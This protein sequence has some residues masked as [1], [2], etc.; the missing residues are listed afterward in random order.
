MFIEPFQQ[1]VRS[2]GADPRS[3]Q[4]V[5]TSETVKLVRNVGVTSLNL[6]QASLSDHPL[7]IVLNQ[8]SVVA[9]HCCTTFSWMHRVHRRTLGVR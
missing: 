1:R 3:D 9:A 4:Y 6:K 8:A 5:Q 2:I 7:S